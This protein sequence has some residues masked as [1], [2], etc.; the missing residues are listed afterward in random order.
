MFTN[1][2]NMSIQTDRKIKFFFQTQGITLKNRNRLKNY[3]GNVLKKEG[4]H[5]LY[6]NYIFCSDRYLL[7]V[8]RTYLAHDYYTDI[9]T[10]DLSSGGDAIEA[11][12]YIS[13]DRI[14][15]NARTVGV[16]ISQ[17]IHR[18][19][20]HGILH[21]CGYKDKSRSDRSKMRLKE[22]HYLAKYER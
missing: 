16:F 20:I 15:E 9:L 4:K 21:L 5:L 10:F 22:N 7:N 3:L 8:N 11:E 6:I 13:I 14:R 2:E 18:V 12:I 17:E 19:M 1:F